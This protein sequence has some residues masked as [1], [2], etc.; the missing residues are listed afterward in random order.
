V[1]SLPGLRIK[2]LVL[3]N[4]KS[5]LATL[6]APKWDMT[7]VLLT[8][9]PLKLHIKAKANHDKLVY[10]PLAVQDLVGHVM[11]LRGCELIAS[12]YYIKLPSRNKW[13]RGLEILLKNKPP[14]LRISRVY[15]NLLTNG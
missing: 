14:L 3:M 10:V 11:W 5:D 8:C 2:Y 13:G 12:A 15:P 7:Q 9:V 1:T 4:Y 6:N